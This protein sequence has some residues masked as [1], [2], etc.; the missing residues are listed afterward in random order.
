MD[1]PVEVKAGDPCP[2]CGGELK[3]APVPTD[4]QFAKAG[5]R[6]NPV[7]LPQGYDTAPKAVREE[8]GALHKCVD[9]GYKTRFAVETTERPKGKKNAA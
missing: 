5:D 7:Y 6:E 3:A 4:E 8:H 9:C 1:K 2:V